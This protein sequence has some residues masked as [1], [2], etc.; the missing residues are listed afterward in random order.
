MASKEELDVAS[1]RQWL[2]EELRNYKAPPYY[3]Q[4][5][6]NAEKEPMR[7]EIEQLAACEREIAGEIERKA[8]LRSSV[9]AYSGSAPTNFPKILGKF[10]VGG[11][12]AGQQGLTAISVTSWSMTGDCLIGSLSLSL[13]LLNYINIL[14]CLDWTALA[15][16]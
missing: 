14:A 16:N 5:G 11:T 9:D 7:R 1:K 13:G 15:R 4:R 3:I 8:S 2:E 6:I 12:D 10:S